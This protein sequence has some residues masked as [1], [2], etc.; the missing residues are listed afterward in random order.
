R[1]EMR[2]CDAMPDEES[3]GRKQKEN[4]N[5]RALSDKTGSQKIHDDADG[6]HQGSD[7]K[8]EEAFAERGHQMGEIGGKEN[9]IDRHI[10]NAAD[11]GEPGFLKTPEGAEGAAY[12][13]VKTSGLGQGRGQF[14][15]HER[16][17]HGP[18]QRSDAENQDG[19]AVAVAADDL[20]QAEGPA[21]DHGV[22]GRN[23]RKQSDLAGRL[24]RVSRPATRRYCPAAESPLAAL[25]PW[26][27]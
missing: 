22:G 16:A 5:D 20:F 24:Q 25:Q 6:D 13:D 21:G 4:E 14:A 1:G 7:E 27:R 17:G 19:P 11:E 3:E 18:E 8:G 9:G 26:E 15:D 2:R 23:Q 12:P 10:E